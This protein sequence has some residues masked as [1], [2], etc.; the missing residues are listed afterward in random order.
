MVKIAPSILSADFLRLGEQVE[1]I[2]KAGAEFLHIDVMDGR[3]VPNISFGFPVIR[4]LRKES[5]MVFDVHLMIEEPSK[6][7]DEFI[8]AGADIVTVHLEADTHIHRTISHIKNRGVKVGVSLNPGTPV[9]MIKDIIGDLDMVLIM[10]V[11]P[12]FGGQSFI[13]NSLNKIR[14]VKELAIKASNENILI[15]VDGG[16]DA[17]TAKEVVEAGANVLVAGSAVFNGDKIEENIKAIRES[18]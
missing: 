10:S 18:I 2:E 9:S 13:K 15:Q 5:K 16:I 1:R 7:V 14:E 11:N 6:F 3:F 8:D 12:G 17:I 4:A